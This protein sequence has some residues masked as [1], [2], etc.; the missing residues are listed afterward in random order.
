[1]TKITTA[2]VVCQ[3]AERGRLGLDEPVT[4]Y[5][6]ELTSREPI[7]IRQ[8]LN[9]SAGLRTGSRCAGSTSRMSPARPRGSSR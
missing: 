5:L 8:L 1:M 6:P 9:H 4:A 7:T 2:T 3:L